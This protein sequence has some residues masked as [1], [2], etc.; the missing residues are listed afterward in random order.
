MNLEPSKIVASDNNEAMMLRRAEEFRQKRLK[1]KNSRAA[2]LVTG[3]IA[4]PN[5]I[6]EYLVQR[7]RATRKDYEQTTQQIQQLE[8]QLHSLRQRQAN[9]EG[10][11]NGH[12]ADLQYWDKD[13]KEVP[14]DNNII[15][16]SDPK[17][18]FPTP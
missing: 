5:E 2:S 18:I 3:E 7:I 12:V 17:L 14:E 15:T 16:L 6:V 1:E 8:T 4:P 10:D 11:H 13:T 9:L